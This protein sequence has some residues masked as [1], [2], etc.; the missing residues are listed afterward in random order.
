MSIRSGECWPD[1]EDIATLTVGPDLTGG[2]VVE[3]TSVDPQ[4]SESVI[5]QLDRSGRAGK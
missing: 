1:G 5:G 3:R 2:Q 4:Q